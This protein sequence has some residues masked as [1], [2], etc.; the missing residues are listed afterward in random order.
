MNN[1]FH[2]THDIFDIFKGLSVKDIETEV[3]PS[4]DIPADA[5]ADGAK[6]EE[7]KASN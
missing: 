1:D 2:K 4:D 3:P 6:A 7:P 5:Q